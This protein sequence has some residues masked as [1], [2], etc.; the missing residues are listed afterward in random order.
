M[1]SKWDILAVLVWV[2]I[3]IGFATGIIEATK[4]TGILLSAIIAV[5]IALISVLQKDVKRLENKR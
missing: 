1:N 5:D 4:V 3:L 2:G